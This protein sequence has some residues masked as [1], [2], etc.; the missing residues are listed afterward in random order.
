MS[1]GVNYSRKHHLMVLCRNFYLAD[2]QFANCEYQKFNGGWIN[3][4]FIL[5]YLLWKDKTQFLGLLI[6]QRVIFIR[7]NI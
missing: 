2:L 5:N 1:R 6:H 3:Q 4:N 7:V